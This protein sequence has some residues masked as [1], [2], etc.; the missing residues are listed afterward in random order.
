M[1]APWGSDEASNE[2]AVGMVK[3]SFGCDEVLVSLWSWWW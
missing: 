2:M 1:E 3:S